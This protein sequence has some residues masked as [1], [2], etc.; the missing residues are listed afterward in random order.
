[1]RGSSRICARHAGFDVTM[2]GPKVRANLTMS[3]PWVR[4]DREGTK[5][6]LLTSGAPTLVLRWEPSLADLESLIFGLLAYPEI[7]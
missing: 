7:T 5:V 4:L 6:D 1:M 2:Y 3:V